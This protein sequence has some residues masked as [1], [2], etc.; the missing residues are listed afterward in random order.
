MAFDQI[1]P[2]FPSVGNYSSFAKHPRAREA[3]AKLLSMAVDNRFLEIVQGPGRGVIPLGI[4]PK[5][6]DPIGRIITDLTASGVN[7]ATKHL[8]MA[9]PSIRDILNITKPNDLIAKIDLK[10]GFFHIPLHESVVSCNVPLRIPQSLYSSLHALITLALIAA[11]TS[12]R[13]SG[14]QNQGVSKFT[15]IS[16]MSSTTH[17]RTR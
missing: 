16:L 3:E 9:L 10:D 15:T 7:G 2:D 4:V 11:C 6:G 12:L 1:P 8:N 5:E 13:N 14:K 17:L